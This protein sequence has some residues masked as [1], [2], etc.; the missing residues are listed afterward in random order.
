MR[1]QVLEQGPATYLQGKPRGPNV[2][3]HRPPF[4]C[5]DVGK[6][7]APTAAGRIAQSREGTA[8]ARGRRAATCAVPGRAPAPVEGGTGGI[9]G[10]LTGA[11]LGSCRQITSH[12]DAICQYPAAKVD[13][14]VTVHRCGAARP[15]AA[16]PGGSSAPSGSRS[17]V[18]RSTPGAASPWPGGGC[19]PKTSGSGP[20]GGG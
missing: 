12:C 11:D 5:P 7:P 17:G 16:G 8:I 6:A 13:P 4:F 14:G 19:H 3:G 18:A 10:S 15:R 20:G 2:G 1:R 9:R